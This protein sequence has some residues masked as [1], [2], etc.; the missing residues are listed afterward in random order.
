MSKKYLMGIDNGGTST[1][2]AIYDMDGHELEKTTVNTKMLTP[3]PFFTERDMNELWKANIYV[4]K[5]TLEKSH[6]DPRNISGI[7][8]TGHGNGLYLVD[9]KGNAVRNGI[10]S[11]DDG[12]PLM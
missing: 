5:Q 2:A 1:K 9:D 12:P 10:I 6:I 3:H 4:I 8:C 7:A 11:T